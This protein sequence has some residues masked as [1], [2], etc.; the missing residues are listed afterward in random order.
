MGGCTTRS[1]LNPGKL[2]VSHTGGSHHEDCSILGSILGF[3]YFGKVPFAA[4][5][6]RWC[7]ISS[8]N[9]LA[10]RTL[11][12]SLQKHVIDAGLIFQEYMLHQN[13]I[14]LSIKKEDV[15]SAC[16]KRSQGR[17][18]REDRVVLRVAKQEFLP[19]LQLRKTIVTIVPLK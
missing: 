1:L 12:V 8:I 13:S 5:T 11:H 18:T 6:F 9:S 3:P 14:S 15:I 19:W 16:P 2:G 10:R 4:R 17:S 7:K